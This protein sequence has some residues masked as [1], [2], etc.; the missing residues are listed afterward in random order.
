MFKKFIHIYIT[1]S[2]YFFIQS[3][4]AQQIHLTLSQGHVG[5]VVDMALSNNAILLA[6]VGEDGALKLW[7]TK[8]KRLLDTIFP[9]EYGVSTLC[10]SE[11]NK[12]LATAGKDR[13]VKI[14]NLEN[15]E[16]LYAYDS[17]DYDIVKM[18]FVQGYLLFINNGGMI[19]RFD[20]QNIKTTP[21]GLEVKVNFGNFSSI[22]Y[23]HTIKWLG[24]GYMEGKVGVWRG[25]DRP[26]VEKKLHDDWISVIDFI[27]KD[28]LI[29]SGSW[30]KTI[31]VWDVNNDKII[32]TLKSPN[33]QP[34]LDLVYAHDHDILM[35]KTQSDSI[36]FY[37]VNKGVIDEESLGVR[38][39]FLLMK[40][41][42]NRK[43]AAFTHKDGSFSVWTLK[44]NRKSYSEV[45]WKPQDGYPTS[46]LLNQN[47]SEV[48]IGLSN[49]KIQ[50]WRPKVNTT[51]IVWQAH[52]G[53]INAMSYNPIQQTHTTAG[54]DSLLKVWDKK[55]KE[56]A[57]TKL[58]YVVTHMHNIPLTNQNCLGGNN[59]EVVLYNNVSHSL[60]KLYDHQR[61][62]LKVE[63]SSSGRYIASISS[64]RSIKVYDFKS[65]KV[66]FSDIISDI[67]IS[68]LS[69]SETDELLLVGGK[70][71]LFLYDTKSFQLIKKV[72]T[73]APV[74]TVV[75]MDKSDHWL[76]AK[77]SGEIDVMND[78]LEDVIKSYDNSSVPMQSVLTFD[79]Q[80]VFFVVRKDM[81]IDLMS[82]DE[83]EAMGNLIITDKGDWVLKHQSGLFDVSDL[84]M[85]NIYYVYGNETIDFDQLKDMY[86][87]PGLAEVLLERQPLRIVPSLSSL[88]LFPHAEI[89]QKKDY[90]W[91]HLND[92]GGGIGTVS[93]FVNNKEAIHDIRKASEQVEK[94][95]KVYYKIPLSSFDNKFMNGEN[96]EITLITTNSENTLS[97]RGLKLTYKG[98]EVDL[99]T[100]PTLY[101]IVVGVSDYR[102]RLLDLKYASKDAKAVAEVMED[103]SENLFGISNTDVQLISSDEENNQPTKEN[104]R[105]AFKNVA[106]KANA[107]DVL[108]VFLAGHGTVGIHENNQEDFYFL[109][110]DMVNSDIKDHHI[111]NNYSVNG[112][113]LMRWIKEIPI[114]KQVFV[115]DACHAG[116]FSTNAIVS[117]DDNEEGLKKRALEKVRSRTGMFMLSGASADK[118]SY[119]SS[120]LKH[121]LLT[122]SLLDYLKFGALNEG[123]FVDVQ[124]LFSYAI[125]RVPELADDMH[126]EQ[127]PEYRMPRGAGSFYIGEL[128]NE[129][130][131]KIS[132][133][134]QQNRISQ[135][136]FE[137][138]KTWVDELEL[139][140]AIRN[141]I[142][143][144]EEKYPFSYQKNSEG[145][146]VYKIKGRYKSTKNGIKLNYRLI[147]GDEVIGDWEIKAQKKEDI[148]RQIIDQLILEFD[149]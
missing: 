117:R 57:K 74:K 133:S 119:E 125:D 12:Y 24:A 128:K 7:N 53:S 137:E 55:G 34:I 66:I 126:G 56:L 60:K 83:T 100:E 124:D 135:I 27:P 112:S 94:N 68:D 54:G 99:V 4:S 107:S 146:T 37:E 111:R 72:A 61:G 9:H 33:N 82:T 130:R 118:V 110:K 96:N 25:Y 62:V 85:N 26:L 16:L 64:D 11:D 102:G 2:L 79:K 15:R 90:L 30:D 49:G 88:K 101:A 6:T 127:Q 75:Y 103:G 39:D 28:S 8:E 18:S 97:G 31:K 63:V 81:S 93:L 21:D 29:I 136:N 148:V 23:N 115:I 5:D 51:S 138:E 10:F 13:S 120:I 36:Y 70:H 71:H 108:F 22:N 76:I 47:S 14:W 145:D 121:G 104:I 132:L 19:Y 73:D 109:T 46:S 67:Q 3:A 113:E 91:I 123:K 32:S 42:Q 65:Q 95:G 35:V 84:N 143:L 147:S 77:M 149:E 52:S 129:D 80:N 86:W 114:S 50:I 116:S 141:D 45:K 78:Y 105:Q 59:G 89:E 144:N 69:F 139:E 140:D 41:T 87:E 58:D 44:K 106:Q 134:L 142:F 98:K 1:L 48:S 43:Y 20:W 40:F 131:E 92:R 17:L 38:D 122:Y